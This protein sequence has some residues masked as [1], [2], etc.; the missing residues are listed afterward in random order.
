MI[1]IDLLIITVNE[2]EIIGADTLISLLEMLSRS[3]ALYTCS[4][5]KSF[6]TVV[7]VVCC[8]PKHYLT[9]LRLLSREREGEKER[10]RESS[11][12]VPLG[13]TSC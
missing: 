6:K 13:Y 5:F 9:G 10:E 2:L 4:L 8:R 7:S 11:V 3:V 1:S 12:L